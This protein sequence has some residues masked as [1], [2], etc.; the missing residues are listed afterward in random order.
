MT[1]D[2]DDVGVTIADDDA[3]GWDDED[4]DWGDLE[5]GETL[6]TFQSVYAVSIY[7]Q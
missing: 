6:P 7:D 4:A 2:N 5:D 3:D 1:F